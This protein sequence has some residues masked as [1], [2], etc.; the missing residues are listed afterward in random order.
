MLK[1]LKN[2][3]VINVE[4][5]EI[6]QVAISIQNDEIQTIDNT[7]DERGSSLVIDMQ[8]AYILPGLISCH[9]HLT[10]VFPFH[11]SD[12]NEDA[13][14]TAFRTYRR[15]QDALKA[16]VTTVRTVG[17]T[18]RADIALRKSIAAGWVTGPRIFSAGL[19]VSVTGGHGHGFT[20]EA[21]GADDF[22]KKCR[23]DLLAG[24]NH[25]KIFL[26]GGIAHKDE[27]FDE[28][29]M[30]DEEIQATVEVAK[31]KGT[32]VC[33]HVGDSG[34][35]MRGV[36]AG[37]RCFE[38]TYNLDA[39]TASAIKEIDGFIVPTLGVTRSKD[40]MSQHGFEEWTICKAVSAAPDHLESIKTAVKAGVT[41]VNGTDIPPGDSDD[42]APIVVREMEHCV[43]AGLS[44]LQAVQTAT[45]NAAKLIR[46][47]NLGVIKPGAKADFIATTANPVE[48][49]RNLREIF[50]V[51]QGGAIVRDDRE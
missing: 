26:T 44:P 5:G 36:K 11:L 49:V 50:F 20:A 10:I 13:A 28:S 41:L 14:M 35:I 32:Y 39:K 47:N 9:T 15:G 27:T 30:S 37:V 42:G 38:H 23:E 19:G 25:I 43:E 48:D 17:E 1:I 45:L 4:N 16:G 3:R 12:P 31:S 22:R 40:W 33:A 29:Q 8:G 46:S 34:P 24:A 2:C 7:V 21:D 6:S 51:M 18:N